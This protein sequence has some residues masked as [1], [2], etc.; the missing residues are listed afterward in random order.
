MTTNKNKKHVN[1]SKNQKHIKIHN[2]IRK[3]SKN[4]GNRRKRVIVTRRKKGGVT[5][6][7]AAK[8]ATSFL[9]FVTKKMGRTSMGNFL[10]ESIEDIAT[11]SL[12]TLL[13][14]YQTKIDNMVDA[15]VDLYQLTVTNLENKIKN[16]QDLFDLFKYVFNFKNDCHMNGDI[17]SICSLQPCKQQNMK[18]IVLIM[19]VMIAKMVFH[20]KNTVVSNG[21]STLKKEMN[22]NNDDDNNLTDVFYFVNIFCQSLLNKII[23]SERIQKTKYGDIFNLIKKVYESSSQSQNENKLDA[24]LFIQNLIREFNAEEDGTKNTTIENIPQFISNLDFLFEIV[25]KNNQITLGQIQ[26]LVSSKPKMLF[27]PKL[28]HLAE[29]VY[30]VVRTELYYKYKDSFNF[31]RFMDKIM[32]KT[33]I[34]DK[35]IDILLVFPSKMLKKYPLLH[36]LFGVTYDDSNLDVLSSAVTFGIG[37]M[38]IKDIGETKTFEHLQ[39]AKAPDITPQIILRNLKQVQ[40][41]SSRYLFG[42]EHQNET[43]MR[44]FEEINKQIGMLDEQSQHIETEEID[45]QIT[46]AMNFT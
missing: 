27:Y 6:N 33:Q 12:K 37:M 29:L 39:H 22:M 34:V 16:N 3:S 15:R 14:R 5:I 42:D 24:E 4:I 2:G 25:K 21:I 20:I 1:K 45:E 26:E 36:D 7:N 41:L 31:I 17:T 40:D 30:T 35:L 11:L 46:N 19:Y 38:L 32:N 9:G 43:E 23:T 44:E 8:Y 18:K 28:K 10:I 13:N